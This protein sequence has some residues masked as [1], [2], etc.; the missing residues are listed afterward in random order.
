MIKVIIVLILILIIR[1][2]RR[3]FISHARVLLPAII[4]FGIGFWVGGSMAS[5]GGPGWLKWVGGVV[6]IVEGLPY[7]MRYIDQIFPQGR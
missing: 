4:L 7:V 3:L 1:P 2:T 5:R 6:F